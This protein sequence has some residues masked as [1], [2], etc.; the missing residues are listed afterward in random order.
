MRGIGRLLGERR[1]VRTLKYAAGIGMKA[2][3]IAGLLLTGGSYGTAEAAVPKLEQIRVA[4]FID[5]GKYSD[6]APA[7]TLSSG[8]GLALSLRDSGGAVHTAAAK[9]LVRVYADGYYAQ[10]PDTADAAQ[11]KAQAQKLAA[12]GKDAGIVQR[13]KRGQPAYQVYLGPYPTKEAASAAAASQ[14]G[15]VLTGPLRLSAGSYSGAAEAQA[16]AAAIAQ[17]GFD[18]DVA[19]LTA[20]SAGAPAYAVLVGGAADAA[21]LQAQRTQLAAALPGVALTPVDAAQQ[22]YVLQRSELA[23]TADAAEAARGFVFGGPVKLWA[24]PAVADASASAGIVVRERGGRAYRGGIELTRHNGKLA[25]INELP[26]EDYLY[27]VVSS[28]LTKDWPLEALKAQ[29]VAA[30]TYALKQGVKYQIAHVADTTI[31]QA[32][33]GLTA[34]FPAAL[35]AVQATNGEVLLYKNALIDPLFYSNAGG[36]TSES[37]EVWGNKVDY[38]KS[39]T[40]PDEG[41]GAGK[42]PWY[43]IVLPNGNTGYIHSDY[44]RATGQLNPAGLEFYVSTG[45]DVSVRSAPYADNAANP[46]LFKVNIGDR[47][48]VIDQVTESNAYAWVRGPIDAAKLRD[49]LASALPAGA[50]AAT[51]D[52]LEISKRGPSGRAL[53]VTANGQPLKAAYPD[54]LRTLLGGL[55]STLFEIE[56]TGRYTILGTGGATRNPSAS[57]T[58]VY[59][60]SG[61]GATMERNE[62]QLFVMD[63]D[64]NVRIVTKS[65]QYIFKGTGLGHGLGMSQWGARG[66]AELGYDYQKILQTYYVGVSVVKG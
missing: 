6:T 39:V 41:A 44:A 54:A 60:A 51:I 66:Y 14:A 3:L 45:T 19:Q 9:E 42:K 65:Q 30:R 17:A 46:A 5:T 58:S 37:T 47:F 52:R 61:S 43:R 15:A 7:V 36:K 22:G 31:D 48:V 28:E 56:E 55:P 13:T 27:S 10:L 63:G 1:A 50:N 8:A 4:L 40:S 20:G 57:S 29:A 49:K 35:Q 26:L 11:A 33:K 24:A 38:L 62:P 32:Y 12:A 2:A 53:E 25:V 16:Q 59:V 18:A 34:E 21:A 64:G 23:V